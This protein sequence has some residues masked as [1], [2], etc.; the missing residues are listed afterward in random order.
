M[1][2]DI[3]STW[4]TWFEGCECNL[5]LHMDG[6]ICPMLHVP[7]PKGSTMLTTLSLF[8]WEACP[9]WMDLPM[10]VNPHHNEQAISVNPSTLQDI[11]SRDGRQTPT[12]SYSCTWLALYVGWQWT[13]NMVPR[14]NAAT[15]HALAVNRRHGTMSKCCN[16]SWAG[17]ERTT[18]YHVEALQ[19]FMRW[20]WTDNMVPCRSVQH[21]MRWQW[22][23]MVPR[24]SAATF[25]ALAV[26][27]QHGTTSKRCNISCAGSEQKTWYHVE[28]LQHFMG[29]QWTDNMV[30]RRSTATFHGLAVNRQHGTT[31]KW[32]NISCA[33]SEQTT[34][35]HVEA[36]QHFM[37]CNISCAGSEQMTWYHVEVLQHFMGWQRTDDMV[38]CRSAATFHGLA[39]NGQHGTTSKHCNISCAGSEQTTWYH[40]E[41][42]QHFM[43]W[44]WTDNMVP[45]RSAATFHALAANRRHGT[46]SKCCNISWAG[47][48]QTTW[49]HVKVLQ[50]FMGLQWTDNM[51]PRRSTA[52]FHALAVN[53]RHGTISKCCN[54]S[55]A[56][57]EQTTWYYVEALQ[58][59][60]RWQW[61][62]DMV[63]CRS[64]ATYHGLAVNGQ[65][66]TTSKRCNI[67]WTGSERTTWY[68]VDVLQHFIL[69]FFAINNALKDMSQV[70]LCT[71]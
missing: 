63:P 64:A 39:V 28:V 13:D 47:S 68:H 56:G 12:V 54:I 14:R 19:H 42:L 22:T 15:F 6:V 70:G 23:D 35:Y 61:T 38:P 62:D 43:G 8:F 45:C 46:M 26:N 36:L 55:W 30:P 31:S 7:N 37:R 11:S 32:C 2:S 71:W 27:G 65:H 33:G 41:V 66:G 67:S 16:I 53:R 48:E 29:W 25:H 24:R 10:K 1:S 9:A 4:I 40:D 20:L 51:V 34:W 3:H 52:T 44:Q 50:H 59:F 18:W 5:F 58:H 49:Y 60:M 69:S 17:S 57:S 21:F